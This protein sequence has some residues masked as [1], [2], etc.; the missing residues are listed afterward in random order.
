MRVDRA[1]Q[2]IA[3]LGLEILPASPQMLAARPEGRAPVTLG[4]PRASGRAA[5]QEVT[6]PQ[7]EDV[8]EH[9]SRRAGVGEGEEVVDRVRVELGGEK[10]RGQQGLRLRA[11]EQIVGRARE[12][13]RLDSE[14]VARED[15][16]PRGR[17]PQCNREHPAQALHELRAELF[18][19]VGQ[20]ARIAGVR[21]PVAALAELAP[22]RRVVVDLAVL[23]HGRAVV[24]AGGG[25]VPALQVH[26]RE[27]DGRELHPVVQVLARV[28]R[29]AV[30]DGSDHGPQHGGTGQ[31]TVARPHQ[32]C[33]ATHA[34]TSPAVPAALEG[35]ERFAEAGW[36]GAVTP[37]RRARSLARVPH[38]CQRFLA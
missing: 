35:A 11:E 16:P 27:P 20:D 18:V 24:A 3:I 8:A 31:R 6:R 33:E 4:R 9:G 5:H 26:D 13:E 12:V 34:S 28:V 2:S 36:G 17:I 25:L 14:A 1:L 30:R 10:A 15:E 32:S 21:D 38:P 37:D 19:Q 22:Q 7:L 29:P 23:H